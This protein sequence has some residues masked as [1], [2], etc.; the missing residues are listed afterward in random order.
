MDEAI[1]VVLG[2]AGFRS[3]LRIHNVCH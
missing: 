3:F 2:T 1:R